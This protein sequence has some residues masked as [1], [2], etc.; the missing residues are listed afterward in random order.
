LEDLQKRFRKI[1]TMKYLNQLFSEFKADAGLKNDSDIAPFFGITVN[2][3]NG[4]KN[5]NKN[6]DKKREIC[7]RIWAAVSELNPVS[8]CD[9][10][11]E[12]I[13]DSECIETTEGVWKCPCCGQILED[14]SGL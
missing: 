10:C 3:F 4:A 11:K 8:I 5:G 14:C 13:P 7:V 12:F 1:V 6:R 9:N 2:S